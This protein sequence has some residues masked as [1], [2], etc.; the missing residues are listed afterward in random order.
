MHPR[1]Q[2]IDA[3]VDQTT[4]EVSPNAKD[5][6]LYVRAN[7]GNPSHHLGYVSRGG[8]G[9]GEA[10]TVTS[11]MYAP[12]ASDGVPV[13]MRIWTHKPPQAVKRGGK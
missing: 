7:M 11:I 5:E 1:M 2:Q 6:N 4:R 8:T 10:S 9:S 12:A 13:R 3:T